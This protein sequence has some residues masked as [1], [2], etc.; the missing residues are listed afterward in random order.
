MML[1]VDFVVA[2]YSAS[3]QGMAMKVAGMIRAGGATV[4]M[5]LEPKKKVALNFEYADR[6]GAHCMVFVAPDEWEKGSVAVK[7]LRGTGDNKQV[8]V[9]VAELGNLLAYLAQVKAEQ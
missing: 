2:A 8:E 7:D 5:L 1:Q 3:M 9:P 4:D 6:A